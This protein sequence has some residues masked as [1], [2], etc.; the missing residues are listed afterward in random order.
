MVRSTILQRPDP[1]TAKFE[2]GSWYP[3]RSNPQTFFGR[4]VDP[5][6]IGRHFAVADGRLRFATTEA[7][8]Q[9]SGLASLEELNATLL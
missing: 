1:A 8:L 2:R 7:F 5:L 9:R 3:G 6:K 4:R